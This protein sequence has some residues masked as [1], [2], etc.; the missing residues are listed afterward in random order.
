MI[1]YSMNDIL[2]KLNRIQ[3]LNS[4]QNDLHENQKDIII[5]DLKNNL[6]NNNTIESS[7]SNFSQSSSQS[8]ISSTFL[9]KKNII[10]ISQILQNT[11]KHLFS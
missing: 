2:K 9:D 1:N 8:D 11:G 5:N 7:V 3:L 6:E 4:I 10:H